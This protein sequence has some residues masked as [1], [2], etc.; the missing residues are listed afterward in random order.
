MEFYCCVIFHSKAG[1]AK[2]SKS[3]CC[4]KQ[5]KKGSRQIDAKVAWKERPQHMK[6]TTVTDRKMAERGSG[7]NGVK[8]G[9]SGMA[10]PGK[11][12]AA[13]RKGTGSK[14]G[15]SWVKV[16]GNKLLNPL[17]RKLAA[18][19]NVTGGQSEEAVMAGNEMSRPRQRRM[20]DR[21]CA[22]CAFH[23]KDKAAKVEHDKMCHPHKCAFCQHRFCSRVRFLF[24]ENPI[25]S[26]AVFLFFVCG[27]DRLLHPYLR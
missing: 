8:T 6:S 9:R 20:L 23:T 17:K 12:W 14:V 21:K 13:D 11:T 7:Q 10:Q 16:A 1:C 3:Q 4:F 24:F 26:S 18:D 5:T 22:Y 15:Q 2:R 19:R 25:S 27:D